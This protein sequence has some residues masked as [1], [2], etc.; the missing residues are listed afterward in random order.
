MADGTYKLAPQVIIYDGKTEY[1][2]AATPFTGCLNGIY[3]NSTGAPD[4]ACFTGGVATSGQNGLMSAADKAKL[5]GINLSNYA[6]ASHA[7]DDRYYT[8]SEVDSK[9]GNI[10]AKSLASTG[11]GNS[12]LTYYQTSEGFDGNSG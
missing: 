8:E 1:V 3:Y 4:G 9:F 6:L 7:H 12:S 10:Q 2:G 5:D 11:Y